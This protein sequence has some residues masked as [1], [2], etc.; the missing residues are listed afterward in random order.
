[1]GITV[2]GE[3]RLI[4]PAHLAYGKKGAPPQIPPNAKLTFDVKCLTVK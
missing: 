4:I 2:G 3:R 1:M